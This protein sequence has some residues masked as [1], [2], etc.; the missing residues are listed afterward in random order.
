[1]AAQHAERSAAA[2]R[3]RR[4]PDRPGRHPAPPSRVSSSQHG[5]NIASARH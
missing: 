5:V 3:L 2:H 4:R 1:L